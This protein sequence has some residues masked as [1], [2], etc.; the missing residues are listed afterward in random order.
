MKVYELNIDGLPGP[1]HHFAGLSP[2]NLASTEH[3]FMLSHPQAAALQSLAKIRLLYQLGFKQAILP[4]QERPNLALLYRLGFRG[5]AHQQLAKAQKEAPALFHAAY[6]SSSMWTANAGTITPSSDS[7]DGRLHFT[8]ANLLSHLHR[9]QETMFTSHL[10]RIIFSDPHYFE[11]HSPLPASFSMADEGAANHNRLC[12][13][14]ASLGLHLFVYGKASLSASSKLPLKYPARQ[15]REAQET[16]VRLHQLPP[17]RVLFAQQN[18]KAIDHGVFH[19]DVI[20]VANESLFL[21]H[22]EA[23]LEQNKTLKSLKDRADFAIKLVEVKKN[24]FSLKDAVKSYFFNSQLLSLPEQKGQ[25]LLISPSACQHHPKVS[26]FIERLITDSENP[27]SLVHFVD[28]DQSMANG[29]GPACL[30]LR[31]PMNEKELS[32]MHQGVLINENLLEHLEQW[33]IKHYR[34]ELKKED[35]LDPLLLRESFSA[36]D[37]LTQLLNL[38]SIYSFQYN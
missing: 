13:H 33:V 18:P 17:E 38:G 11:H 7:Q 15:T 5:P 24:I 19:N 37:E 32:S 36:L 26:T 2:G 4:P 12:Q 10:F 31:V 1:T 16:L 29:G 27:I 21:V 30:R 14:H 34:A 8:A 28:L 20:A 3:A 25:M 35:L 6:S 9:A 23:F 22:E